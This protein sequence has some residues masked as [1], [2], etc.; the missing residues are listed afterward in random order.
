LSTSTSTSPKQDDTSARSSTPTIAE[1]RAATQPPSLFERNSGEHWTG[2]LYMRRLSPYVTR[3]VLPTRISATAVTWATLV[4]GLAAAF[5]VSLPGVVPAAGA[6]ALIQLQMLLDCSDGEIARWRGQFSTAGVYMDRMSH[7]VT[8]TAFPVALGVRAD[9]GWDSLGGWTTLGLVVAVLVLLIRT[10]SALVHVARAES[11]KPLVK[12]TEAVAA[13]R[14]RG[15]RAVR[16]AFGYL[17]FYRAFVAIEA[18]LL[19]F[20]AAVVDSIAGDLV[21]TRVLLVALLPVAAVTAAGHLV[22]ILASDRLR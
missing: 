4:A 13:P 11:G 20:V 6:V 16:H 17:P 2:R 10:E 14:A 7:Y 15:L 8:E 21:G 22:A 9:G 12:D 3:A 5:L 19:A 1:L 18:S